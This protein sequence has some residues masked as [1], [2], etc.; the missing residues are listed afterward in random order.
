MVGKKYEKNTNNES[1]NESNIVTLSSFSIFGFLLHGTVPY[2]IVPHVVLPGRYSWHWGICSASS[3]SLSLSSSSLSLSQPCFPRWWLRHQGKI[4]T[5]I[6]C[7]NE[8]TNRILNRAHSK[9]YCFINS[10]SVT[11]CLHSL[12]LYHNVSFASIGI[13]HRY[14]YVYSSSELANRMPTPS[15]TFVTQNFPF[16][17]TFCV[18]LANTKVNQAF[19]F[20]HLVAKSWNSSFSTLLPLKLF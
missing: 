2:S 10:P 9:G 14:L 1:Y 8:N 19:H 12:T 18:H 7:K 20:T 16:A 4:I 11:E 17:L 6:W 5:A 15:C 3:P 13:F